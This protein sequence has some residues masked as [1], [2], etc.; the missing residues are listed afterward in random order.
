MLPYLPDTSQIDRYKILLGEY[1]MRE[2]TILFNSQT[3]NKTFVCYRLS[4]ESAIITRNGGIM[5]R[6]SSSADSS[7]TVDAVKMKITS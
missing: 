3:Q 2:N 7:I 5:T 1:N 6:T 4:W